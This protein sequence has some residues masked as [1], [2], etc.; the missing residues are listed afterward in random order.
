MMSGSVPLTTELAT[1]IRDRLISQQELIKVAETKAQDAMTKLAAVAQENQVL[2][3]VLKLVADGVFD[4]R[5]A[6]EKAAA[7]VERPMDLEVI[8]SA[9]ELGIDKFETKL[10]TPVGEARTREKDD[11]TSPLAECL[12]DLVNE[13]LIGLR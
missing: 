6:M 4:P 12:E 11:G 2:R 10:G 5:D 9:H 8:K 13:G 7:F 3:T 1:K